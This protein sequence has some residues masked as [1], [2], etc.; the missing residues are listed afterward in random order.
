M[1]IATKTVAR[2][3]FSGT[4]VRAHRGLGA[5]AAS[6]TPLRVFIPGAHVPILF[7]AFPLSF[8]YPLAG[9]DFSNGVIFQ[10]NVNIKYASNGELI[11]VDA[12]VLR[13][14]SWWIIGIGQG[15]QQSPG[16]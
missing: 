5:R 15:I 8:G 2:C 1:G 13:F 7:L 12:A 14:N 16:I 11:A 10:S 3:T 4:R 6:V 9:F